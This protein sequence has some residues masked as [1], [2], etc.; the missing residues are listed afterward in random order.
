MSDP[1]LPDARLDAAESPV[2]EAY[3]PLLRDL[4]ERL[5]DLY[6]DRLR[7]VIVYGSVAR[8]EATPE[9]DVDVLVVLDGPVDRFEENR[10]IASIA[11]AINA[12]YGEFVTPLVVAK[13][14]FDSEDWPLYRSIHSEGISV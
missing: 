4:R 11:V 14:R 9:S 10:R 1:A 2:S 12:S 3:R 5:T 6:G 7:D 8:G 13:D